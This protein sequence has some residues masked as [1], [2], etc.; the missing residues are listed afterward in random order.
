MTQ[1]Y[2]YYYMQS[3]DYSVSMTIYE[4]SQRLRCAVKI[5]T[6]AAADPQIAPDKNAA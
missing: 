6:P 2:Y 1:Y 5:T 4:M 3:W